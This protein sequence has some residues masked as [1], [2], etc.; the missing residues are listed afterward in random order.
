MAPATRQRPG[1]RK[2]R[3]VATRR[4]RHSTPISGVPLR[5]AVRDEIRRRLEAERLAWE[6][7]AAALPGLVAAVGNDPATRALR[8]A[9]RDARAAQ[10][11]LRAARVAAGAEPGE[12]DDSRE[13]I[14]LPAREALV[15]DHAVPGAWWWGERGRRALAAGAPVSRE[16]RRRG[17]A[18]SLTDVAMLSLL[19]GNWPLVPLDA[20]PAAVIDAEAAAVRK[21]LART[22]AEDGYRVIR[23]TRGPKPAR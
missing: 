2:G 13:W 6:P 10:A 16:E 19:A 17:L 12:P 15:C 23:R 11:R 3:N 14:D 22:G 20:K 4:T 1:A 9:E 18:P 21:V 7:I 5:A 8:L